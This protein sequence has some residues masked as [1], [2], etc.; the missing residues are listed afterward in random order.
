MQICIYLFLLSDKRRSTCTLTSPNPYTDSITGQEF[1]VD[2]ICRYLFGN[3]HK[4]AYS[5]T[6]ASFTVK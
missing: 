6:R 4:G 5:S 3:C 2:I 1:L